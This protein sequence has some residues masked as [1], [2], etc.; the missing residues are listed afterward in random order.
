[1]NRRKLK[2]L[3]GKKRKN[4]ECDEIEMSEC[5][6]TKKS[7]KYKKITTKK[8][9]EE[10]K[11]TKAEVLKILE[12]KQDEP[13]I[14]ENIEEDIKMKLNDF[15]QDVENN[16]DEFETYTKTNIDLLPIDLIDRPYPNYEYLEVTD[17]DI[18]FEEKEFQIMDFQTDEL[19]L[20]PMETMESSL[21]SAQ[22]YIMNRIKIF[23]EDEPYSGPYNFL[24]ESNI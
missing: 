17:Y 11:D 18:N 15:D 14:K 3:T 10:K 12:T 13:A 23:D 5:K 2:K 24:N 9:K 22:P 6:S 7:K 16:V 8:L 21:N 4:F 1:M 19:L 20:S